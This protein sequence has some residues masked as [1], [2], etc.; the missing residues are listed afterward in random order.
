MKLR[1]SRAAETDLA[2]AAAYY[3]EQFDGLGARLLDEVEAAL[4]RITAFPDAWQPLSENTRRCRLQRF[5]YGVIYRVKGDEVLVLAVAHL[6]R[7]PGH[8]RERSEE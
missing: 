6:H 5:T 2:E 4:G 8:W 7:E 3:D 1:F